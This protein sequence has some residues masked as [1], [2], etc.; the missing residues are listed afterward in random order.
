M[1]S[2]ERRPGLART[3]LLLTPLQLTLR[4]GEAVFPLFLAAWFGSSAQTDV[5]VFAATLFTFAGALVFAAY[6][7]SALIPILTDL[8]LH[9]PGELPEVVGALL[10]HTALVAAG[11]G[12][13]VAGAAWLWFQARYAPPLQ[14]LAGSLILPLTLH[15]VAVALSFLLTAVLN[16][17][18]RF[19]A[20]PVGAALGM[21]TTLGLLA[22]GRVRHGVVAI[23]W[24]QL[25]G[26]LVAVV[27]LLLLTRLAAGV[28]LRFTR[29][30]PDPVR[31][32]AAQMPAHL[33]GQ[34][35]T[36]LNPLVD[37]LFAQLVPLAG[38]TT[39]L[40]LAG[41]VP[42]G[43]SSLLQAA[44]LP[45][46]LS[47]LSEDFARGERARFRR[48]VHR[49]LAA[50]VSLL[51]IVALAMALFRRPLLRL[52]YLRGEMTIQ[53]VEA[54]SPILL[55]ALVG[56]PG[57]GALLVLARAHIAAGNTRIMVSMGALNAGTNVILNAVLVSPLGLSGITL[58]TSLTN[59]LVA[60]VFWFRLRTHL[61][62]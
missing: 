28:R 4:L 29:R 44:L 62:T 24:A 14:E 26:E 60:V 34:A 61:R 46:L 54:M 5:Y 31:R 20:A 21:G 47:H 8:R 7:D 55:T 53:A 52:L 35:I 11:W 10:V 57:F 59:L 9:R 13:L 16:A 15:L 42:G 51:A 48:S 50:V 56:L 38:G 27:T 19:M 17:Q 12:L 49:A 25:A 30:L 41:D 58:A 33:G 18:R 40:K 36:R 43:P 6:R 2:P 22:L 39:L 1:T 45:V 37:Q 3:A 23:A 32:F